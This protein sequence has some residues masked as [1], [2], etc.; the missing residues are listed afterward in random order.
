MTLGVIDYYR[1]CNIASVLLKYI[2]KRC[3]EDSICLHVHVSNEA[4]IMFYKKHGFVIESRIKDY[5][6]KNAEVDPPDA[7]FLVK[8]LHKH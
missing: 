4:A 6:L 2:L 1:R 7:L 3:K 5:Y 8:R